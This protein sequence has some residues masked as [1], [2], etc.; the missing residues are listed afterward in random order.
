MT[1]HMIRRALGCDAA[2]KRLTETA[3]KIKFQATMK[4]IAETD[5]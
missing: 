4:R 5:R 3:D 2:A 1:D